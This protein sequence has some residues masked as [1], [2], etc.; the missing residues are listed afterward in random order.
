MI[1]IDF[2][3]NSPFPET[4]TDNENCKSV[5][6]PKQSS[7]I[8][9]LPMQIAPN[10]NRYENIMD[11]SSRQLKY[12]KTSNKTLI[13]FGF[14]LS[15]GKKSIFNMRFSKWTGIFE[16]FPLIDHR[17]VNYIFSLCVYI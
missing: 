8:Y 2:L 5:F 16:K 6:L 15:G 4:T 17:L 3:R 11:S 13:L 9:I 14:Q 10:R 7:S 1:Q 12:N